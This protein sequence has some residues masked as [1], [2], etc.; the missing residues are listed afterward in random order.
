M[1]KKVVII[2]GVA[3]GASTA[4]RLRRNDETVQIVMF[5]K[6][7][8]ISFANCGLPYYIGETITERSAL[9]V[10][11][12]E[13]MKARFNIDVRVKSEVL[14]INKE[15][16][17]VTVKDFNTGHSYEESYDILVLSPGSV[18]LKPPIQG[19]DSPNIFSLW[20]I[21]D[22]DAIK[23]Y[24]DEVKPR[25]AAVIGGGFIGLEMA[26][27]LYDRN[28]D[29]TLVEMADQVMAPIDYEM[30]TQVHKHMLQKG[31]KLMLSDG[32]KSFDYKNGVTTITLQSGKTVE[33][34][35]VILSIGIRAQS[36][37]AKDAGLDVNGRG[38]IVVDDMLK[39]SDP[40]IYA[41]GDAIEV[42]DFLGG[43]KTMVPLA[44]PANKQGRICANNICGDEERYEG[45]QGTAIAKVFDLTVASTGMNEKT[46]KREGKVRGQDYQVSI[47][48]AK[49]HAGYYPGALPMALKL[50]F[51]LDGK[52]LGSQIVGY[53]GVDK[54]I[55][56]I[57]TAIR[58]GATIYDL[59]KLELAY[60]PPYSSAKDPVNMAGF[61]AENILKG[62]ANVAH[63][64]EVATRD[65]EKTLLVDVR[66]GIER[67]MGYIEGSINIPL[68]DLRA[69]M[70]ELDPDKEII[71]YCAIG[72]RGYVGV[73]MLMQH[74]FKQVKNL[75]GGYTTYSHVFCEPEMDEDEPTNSC[76]KVLDQNFEDSGDVVDKTLKPTGKVVKVNACGLQCPGPI[77][78]VHQALELLEDGDVLEITATDPGFATD[79]KTWCKKVGHT[80]MAAGKADKQFYAHIMKGT[81]E[82][83]LQQTIHSIPNNK[84]MVVFSD[85]LDRAIASLIIANGAASMGR[86][87]TMFYTFWGLNILK[88]PEKV[89]APKDFMGKMFGMMLPRGT[90]KL[91]L[92]QMNMMGMGPIMIRKLMK[93]KNVDSLETLLQ[94]ALKSGVRM[95]ACNMSMDLMGI[96]ESELIDGV[97]LGG[98]ATYLGE[99]EDADVNLFI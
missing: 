38:G 85:D 25:R 49:S 1:S 7:E 26:E 56:V 91:K 23:A 69:R 58:F 34:D 6:G 51:D 80:L 19:I 44:A 90:K 3:G 37:L 76:C 88:R 95:V 92:S 99:A 27:N 96:H 22:T 52:V 61:T 16:K 55:D 79:I 18:P 62:K 39:T 63:Y 45:T 31:V 54:R 42:T 28:V 84:T 86:K 14:K 78:Q 93:D 9:L 29:V 60:A 32:V 65:P 13:A 59:M 94:M 8:Y 68:N 87:V 97:E 10:Q 57:A 48:H 2:G 66:D 36:E 82:N 53:D 98:V 50:V 70:S 5:E 72:L 81:G 67:E 35:M 46:L 4:A 41:I 77:M 40:S 89:N 75:S 43:F 11:T 47:I 17:T 73:R 30:A 21:P 15:A 64:D 83:K 33:V 24:V 20:N 74:G 12:P 71:L